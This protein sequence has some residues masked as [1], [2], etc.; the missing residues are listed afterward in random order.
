[1]HYTTVLA[2]AAPLAAIALCVCAGIKDGA[3]HSLFLAAATFCSGFVMW[4]RSRYIAALYLNELQARRQH[5]TDSL[6]RRFGDGG[7]AAA[8][9]EASAQH[10]DARAAEAYAA[11]PPMS[12][13]PRTVA[14][15][16]PVLPAFL[17]C[18]LFLI[19]ILSTISAALHAIAYVRSLDTE[20]P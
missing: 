3:A 5:F 6:R 4:L 10:D 16:S 18:C 19:S 13:P 8:V 7:T 12:R 14:R 9:R 11:P 15:V 20:Q 1:M 17:A 2:V